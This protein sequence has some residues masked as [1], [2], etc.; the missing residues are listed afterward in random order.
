MREVGRFPAPL[1]EHR[2]GT[3]TVLGALAVLA[4]PLPASSPQDSPFVVQIERLLDL[5]VVP[6]RNLA[7]VEGLL[8]EASLGD[9]TPSEAQ[10]LLG[11]A[12]ELLDNWQREWEFAER[13][14]VL[15]TA[16][17]ILRYLEHDV[18]TA[19][20]RHSEALVLID[21]GELGEARDLLSLAIDECPAGEALLL[22]LE[23]LQAQVLVALW[24]DRDA[25]DALDDLEATIAARGPPAELPQGE[26]TQ[27]CRI[28]SAR[29]LLY[30]NLGLLEMATHRASL[31][32]E[33]G[34]TL[35][36]RFGDPT[37]R[38]HAEL[39]L[40]EVRT[41]GG[42]L[43]L[44]QD[45]SGAIVG[46]ASLPGDV[47]SRAL[48]VNAFARVK[49]ELEDG[50][51][52]G[53]EA[54]LRAALAHPLLPSH[55]RVRAHLALAELLVSRKDTE[56]VDDALAAARK[57]LAAIGGFEL[58]GRA[59]EAARLAGLEGRRALDSGASPEERARRLEELREAWHVLIGS[60][61]D[62]PV[63]PG[64]VS[65]LQL[66][67][68]S[69]VLGTLVR[70]CLAMEDEGPEAALAH[71]LE[72]QALGTLARYNRIPPPKLADVRTTLLTGRAGALVFFTTGA[73]SHLFAVDGSAVVHEKLPPRGELFDLADLLSENVETLQ[74]VAK[75]LGPTIL[76]EAISARVR[77]W[78]HVHVVGIGL[79]R[80]LLIEA[81]PLA[82]GRALG[83]TL[84][85]S[86]LPS[87]PVGVWLTRRE[88]ERAPDFDLALMVA[89]EPN[90]NAVSRSKKE[91]VRIELST[92]ELDALVEGFPDERVKPYLGPRAVQS[93]IG[94]HVAFLHLLAHGLADEHSTDRE[95]PA[96]LV[97]ASMGSGDDGLLYCDEVEELDA[98]Q[99]VFLSACGTARGP[100]RLGD[101]GVEHLGGAFLSAGA[102]AVVLSSEALEL[103][104]TLAFEA[105]FQRELADGAT[106]AEAL[107]AARRDEQP[108]FR[109]RLR[110]MG[111]GRR[112]PFRR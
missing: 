92:D 50:S 8:R 15:E 103:R 74:E 87:L 31:A 47:R 80:D 54:A 107:L 60:W 5:D 6:V 3:C 2:A 63:R 96:A 12:L 25:E 64:G 99:V 66:R 34:R 39:R 76:T 105:V 108:P 9:L 90:A 44:A 24:Q 61:A 7:Q 10:P 71:V 43:A 4:L 95:R 36:G 51:D 22:D 46:L 106:V 100:E 49:R 91:L 68:R 83:L 28:E 57:D 48:V 53:G 21:E 45:A 35:E 81:L 32:I 41:V 69:E 11:V 97:L 55:E 18:F 42:R 75:D 59:M 13:R 70:L 111:L 89:S 19:F 86:H 38:L 62:R 16:R 84:P 27:L 30:Q 88:R 65:F 40:A 94:D 14:G 102:D 93:A 26:L 37:E 77:E 73:A 72:A 98:P 109:T 33:R 78:D 79:V 112:A 52:H 58:E 110:I 1:R 85:V 67:Q 29:A 20:F 104:A 17:R 101:D 56:Q 23:L 82:G